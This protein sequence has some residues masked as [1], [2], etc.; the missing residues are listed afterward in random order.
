MSDIYCPRCGEPWDIGEF[1]DVP[2]LNFKRALHR[3]YGEGCGM[4][5]N[6]KSCTPAVSEQ[7]KTSAQASAVL[8]E[9]LSDDVDGISAMLEDFAL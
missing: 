6:G 9:V 2:G 8:R 7:A 1:H 4:V 5:F 3:F